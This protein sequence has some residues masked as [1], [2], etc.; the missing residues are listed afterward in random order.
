MRCACIDIGSNTTRLLV[1]ERRTARGCARCSQQ[2]AFTRLGAAAA[3]GTIGRGQDRRGRRRRRRRRS[4]LA[5]ELGAERMRAV[6]TA[7]IRQRAQPRRAASPRSRREPASTVDVLT[8]EEE[9]RARV[10]SA[11]PAR[12]AAPPDGDGRRRR[13]RRRLDRARRRHAWRAASRGRRRCRI[14]SGVL[15][16]ALPARRPAVADAELERVRAHVRRRLRGLSSRRG[17]GARVRRRRQRDVAAPAGRRGARRTRRSSAALRVLCG[18]P[19]RARSPRRFEPATPS[20]CGCCPPGS[21]VLERRRPRARRA[22]AGRPGRPARGRLLEPS[23][24][25]RLMAKAADVRA[26]PRA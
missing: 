18:A 21:L 4:R 22:A 14:G 10:R 23:T 24:R 12:S 16:D 20:A 17:R 6:A 1:A 8:G 15:A 26:R 11:R 2:R 19:R 13:R 25:S 5:R 7:A 9:A 3:D